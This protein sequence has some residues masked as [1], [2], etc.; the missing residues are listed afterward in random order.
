MV[1]Y[2]FLSFDIDFTATKVYL[3]LAAHAVSSGSNKIEQ[4]QLIG[5]FR[6]GIY[7]KS[8]KIWLFFLVSCQLFSQDELCNL[9]RGTLVVHIRS[10]HFAFK[11]KGRIES[12]RSLEG[13]ERER[14]RELFYK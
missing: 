4:V 6:E 13:R 5:G 2:D 9:P 7:N 11:R 10:R 1:N 12:S 8:S 3:R 14:E